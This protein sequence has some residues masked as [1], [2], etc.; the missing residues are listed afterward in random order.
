MRKSTQDFN[1][2]SGATRAVDLSETTE[3]GEILSEEEHVI[4]DLV[5]E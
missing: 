1:L 5:S 3:D 2:G 4:N